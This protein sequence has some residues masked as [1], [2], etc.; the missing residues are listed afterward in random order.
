MRPRYRRPCAESERK[1]ASGAEDGRRE[2]VVRQSSP[3]D[4][5]IAVVRGGAAGTGSQ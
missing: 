2:A 4:P 5:P 1:L 3:S